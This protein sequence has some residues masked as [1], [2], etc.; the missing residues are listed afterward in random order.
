MEELLK[1][2]GF[3]SAIVIVLIGFVIFVGKRFIISK[4]SKG[5]E[6]S[7][8]QK[9]E[10]LKADLMYKS[11][12]QLAAHGAGISAQAHG[13]KRRIEA[14][15][16]LWQSALRIASNTP[17]GELSFLTS[18]E[19]LEILNKNTDISD[20][21]VAGA[22]FLDDHD[23]DIEQLR[24]FLSQEIWRLYS[25]LK[26]FTGRLAYLYAKWGNG[27]EEALWHKDKAILNMLKQ[28]LSTDEIHNVIP[29]GPFKSPY[30]AQRLL[31]EKILSEAN[32]VVSGERFG[33]EALM[34]SIKITDAALA[35]KSRA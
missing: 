34:Q 1:T 21:R 3:S 29:E 2:V 30:G 5:V 9:L 32:L 24:P 18:S 11:S 26:S 20:E 13:A 25:F 22:A 12:T 31:L 4:V 14:L 17:F 8:N 35:L 33:K 15:E 28:V 19:A 16:K 7:F 27:N 10:T 23:D 6:H